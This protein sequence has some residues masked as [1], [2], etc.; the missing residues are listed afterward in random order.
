[1]TDSCTHC[2]ATPAEYDSPGIAPATLC[3][4]CWNHKFGWPLAIVIL[5]FML[6]AGTM[7]ILA[8]IQLWQALGVHN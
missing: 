2:G 3:E 4:R 6:S 8:L 5:C 1:M 7:L